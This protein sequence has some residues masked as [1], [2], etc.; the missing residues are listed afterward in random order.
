VERI[1]DDWDYVILVNDEEQHSLWPEFK[2]VPAGWTRVGPIG[3][4]ATCL[5]WIEEH[6]TD[7]RPKSIRRDA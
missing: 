5:A 2:D 6:W 7:I 4:K 1:S 3:D